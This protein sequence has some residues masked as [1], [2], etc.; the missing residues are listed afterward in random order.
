MDLEKTS[1]SSL[2]NDYFD[3]GGMLGILSLNDDN[4]KLSALRDL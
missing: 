2:F 4:M 1:I 3:Y